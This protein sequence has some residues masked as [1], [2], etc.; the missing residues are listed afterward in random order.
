MRNINK[1]KYEKIY[2]EFFDKAI[3]DDNNINIINKI[4]EEISSNSNLTD[5][6]KN[7]MYEDIFEFV[8]RINKNFE[9]KMEKIY[10]KGIKEGS[11][12][13]FMFNKENSKK[14]QDRQLELEIQDFILER[15]NN[16]SNL[17]NNSD[18]I[19]NDKQIEKFI[20]NIKDNEKLRLIKKLQNLYDFRNDISTIES[21][22]IGFKDCINFFLEIFENK[23]KDEKI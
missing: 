14:K 15:I 10:E 17:I 18:Y 3:K 6:E 5:K 8:N 1:D 12:M 22:T 9:S 11:I 19:N 2:N 20:S 13:S 16:S 4:L 23:L 7:M 21:Y